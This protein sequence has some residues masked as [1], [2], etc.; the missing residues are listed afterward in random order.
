MLCAR[1]PL[2]DLGNAERWLARFGADFRFC[3]ELGWFWWDSRRWKLLSEE[4]DAVPAELMQSMAMTVRAI[5]NEANLV[6]ASGYPAPVMSDKEMRK[7][8]MEDKGFKS[9]IS[10]GVKWLGVQPRLGVNIE[11]VARG[12]WPGKPHSDGESGPP[13]AD[14]GDDDMPPGWNS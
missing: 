14:P 12:E 5:R 7:G 1:L 9:I 2:T 3:P 6:A 10:N 11:D 8:A 13:E 4:K